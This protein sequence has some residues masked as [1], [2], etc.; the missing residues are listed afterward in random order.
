MKFNNSKT[1]CGWLFGEN[2]ILI[3][4]IIFTQDYHFLYTEWVIA[5]LAL[6]IP[7][8][9]MATLFFAIKSLRPFDCLAKLGLVLNVLWIAFFF[10]VI[11]GAR[12]IPS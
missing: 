6:L 4:L 8:F 7:F 9:S 12:L 2:A 5:F 11:F 10:L 1:Y 3:L